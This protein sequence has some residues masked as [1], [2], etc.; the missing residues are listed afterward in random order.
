MFFALAASAAI[1]RACVPPHDKYDFCN[2]KLPMSS[3]VNDLISRLTLD[4]K[5]TLLIARNSP[6]GNVSRLGIPEYDW[7]GNC[8]HGVQSRCGYGDDGKERCP[9]SYPDPNYLGA[10]FN[11]SVWL[12]KAP[13]Y[14]CHLGRILLKMVAISPLLLA[15]MGKT[16]GVELRSLWLQGIG[17]NHAPTQLPHIGLDCWSPNVG[18]NRE[19]PRY[20][21]HLG[22]ILDLRSSSK[23]PAVCRCRQAWMMITS[24]WAISTAV[25]GWAI[26]SRRT[27]RGML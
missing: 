20:R 22:C 5:P 18:I 6:K 19:P 25:V 1:P 2:P 4:E 14:R 24:A 16:I 10:S 27:T 23:P 3:R 15:G 12:G 13:R 11:K 7:G 17:E 21:Y 8:I 26:A 9:T